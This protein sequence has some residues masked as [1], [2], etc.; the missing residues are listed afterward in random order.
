MPEVGVERVRRRDAEALAR[1]VGLGQPRH[2]LRVDHE[3]ACAG[4]REDLDRAQVELDL[5]AVRS[6]PAVGSTIR[7]SPPLR[8]CRTS[9]WVST[10]VQVPVKAQRLIASSGRPG[11]TGAR[12]RRARRSE[13]SGSVRGGGGA[14][15]TWPCGPPASV[16]ARAASCRQSVTTTG[17][18]RR[19]SASSGAPPARGQRA[20]NVPLHAPPPGQRM[21]RARIRLGV[22]EE[23]AGD[24][25]LAP[26][27]RERQR[28]QPRVAAERPHHL[29][30]AGRGLRA[31]PREGAPWP[32]SAAPGSSSAPRRARPRRCRRQAPPVAGVPTARAGKRPVPRRCGSAP[33]RPGTSGLGALPRA[34]PPR[35]CC[36]RTAR[37]PPAR[38]PAPSA[39]ARR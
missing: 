19:A 10:G 37:A 29:L 15:E 31:A 23:P 14:S 25:P 39:L 17:V 32:S 28:G 35:R 8:R 30:G 1:L 11:S 4:L 26:G 7:S 13:R 22:V 16:R 27:V 18:S 24:R 3:R 21:G 38:P 12:P 34:P 20:G 36:R 9:G 33:L 6:R 5:I 2:S